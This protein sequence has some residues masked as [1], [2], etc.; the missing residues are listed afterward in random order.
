MSW[1]NEFY[2]KGFRSFSEEG[3]R[4]ENL[5]KINLL[6]GTNNVGKS[7]IIRFMD[8]IRDN[9]IYKIPQNSENIFW[10]GKQGS[11]ESGM[12]LVDPDNENVSEVKY[13]LKY[14]EAASIDGDLNEEELKGKFKSHIK[15]YTDARGY[16]KNTVDKLVPLIGGIRFTDWVFDQAKLDREWFNTY[17]LKMNEH[18]SALLEEEVKFDVIGSDGTKIEDRGNKDVIKQEVIE[19]IVQQQKFGLEY[20]PEYAEFEILLCRN[21]V[22]KKFKLTELGMGV[23]QYV[24]LLSALYYSQDEYLNIFIEEP[25]LNMHAKALIELVKILETN[26][27][28]KKHRYFLLTHSSVIIDQVSSSYNIY[29]IERRDDRSTIAKLCN[30]RMD[31]NTILDNI[32]ILPSQL[33]QS[34]CVIWV[35]GPSDKIYLKN[36]IELI[37]QEKGFTFIEGRHFSFVYYGGALLDHYR[38]LFDYS[39][40]EDCQEKNVDTLID[41]MSTSRYAAIVCDS[42]IGGSRKSL[43]PRL[44]RVVDRLIRRQELDNNIFTWITEGREIENYIP[45]QLLGEVFCESLDNRKYFNY[46]KQKR[47]L[48]KPSLTNILGEF[49]KTDSF[50]EFFANAFINDTDRK[51]NAYVDAL[52]KNISRDVDKIDIAR[53]I[54]DRWTSKH[55]S[56]ELNNKLTELVEFIHKAQS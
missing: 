4:F 45:H 35:E 7:N 33:L 22:F 42:D 3:I 21:K 19:S 27:L 49:S 17:R 50:D 34:N 26:P 46:N 52:I 56:Q 30:N 15:V 53:K 28:F 1:I 39:D 40:L 2:I 24:L 25:E 29:R 10:D 14:G 38:I 31:L 32:G 43:K 20:T 55:L 16:S 41:I 36:W 9:K 48:P 12:T 11:I 44:Q 8:F 47:N 23:M 51:D 13:N 18:L 5:N 37:A 54:T 6:I